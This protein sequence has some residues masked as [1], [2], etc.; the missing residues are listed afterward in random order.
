VVDL[1]QVKVALG[2]RDP[3]QT[4]EAL[5]VLARLSP[6][7]GDVPALVAMIEDKAFQD[8]LGPLFD[9]LVAC[10]VAFDELLRLA[11]SRRPNLQIQGARALGLLGD[12]AA[13]PLMERRLQSKRLELRDAAARSL[14]V[15]NNP[16]DAA[17][18]LI[19]DF[20]APTPEPPAREPA[21][22]SPVSS[23]RALIERLN[24]GDVDFLEPLLELLME[25]EHDNQTPR[26]PE[27]P[28]SGLEIEIIG[29]VT[30]FATK[31]AD[32]LVL[33]A[34]VLHELRRGRYGCS[35]GAE[36]AAKRAIDDLTNTQLISS[37]RAWRED[38][39]G[40]AIRP[41][42]SSPM[43]RKVRPTPA[44]TRAAKPT[45]R[46]RAKPVGPTPAVRRSDEAAPPKGEPGTV[47]LPPSDY[48]DR[49]PRR[50]KPWWKFW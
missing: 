38:L 49:P 48:W 21:V 22:L 47:P 27:D 10:E 35:V 2:S 29:A 12:S 23:G 4:A 32:S 17:E 15:L 7:A 8:H 28:V 45:P 43:L 16:P 3:N 26:S 6:E 5:D 33:V 14:E 44:R 25:R 37:Y 1:Q 9:A 18:T 31:N 39:T 40:D 50:K 46:Y 11:R 30:A 36:M 19:A 42:A 34:D 41:D 13:I 24:Q 20:R